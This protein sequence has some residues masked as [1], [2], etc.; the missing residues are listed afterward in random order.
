MSLG[1]FVADNILPVEPTGTDEPTALFSAPR[2]YLVSIGTVW[3]PAAAIGSCI[4]KPTISRRLAASALFQIRRSATPVIHSVTA[5]IGD[6]PN[7]KLRT[8]AAGNEADEGRGRL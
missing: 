8:C 7:H 6:A 3:F 2:V 4:G 1:G 5:P